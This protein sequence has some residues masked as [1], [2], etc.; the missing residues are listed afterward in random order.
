MSNLF[1]GSTEKN[2]LNNKI[3]ST[4]EDV[5]N[6]DKVKKLINSIV[7]NNERY[8]SNRKEMQKLIMKEYIRKIDGVASN[9]AK[10]LAKK[11]GV[12]LE[13]GHTIVKPHTRHYNKQK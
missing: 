8:N 9:E 6:N 12:I 7:S 2:L 11:L 13:D 3:I 1:R 5:L 4:K 10:S